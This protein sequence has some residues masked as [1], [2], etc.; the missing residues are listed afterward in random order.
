M[1]EDFEREERA[2]AEALH[3]S[4]P[5][6]TFRP[7]D[8]EAIKAAARPARPGRTRLFKGMA[9]AAVLVIVVGVGAV[10]LPRMVGSAGSVT[11]QPASGYGAGGVVPE[12]ATDRGSAASYPDKTATSTPGFRWE[13]YR[14]IQAEVPESWVYASAPQSDYCTSTRLPSKPYV[15]LNHGDGAVAAILCGTEL[16][17]DQQAL[18]VSFT[19]ADGEPPWEAPSQVWKQSSRIVGDARITVT[20]REEDSALVTSILESA[21]IVADGTT[22]AGCPVALGA[23]PAVELAGLDASQV[24][25]CQYERDSHRGAFRSSV[26][27]TGSDA[28]AAWQ[29]LLKTPEGGGPDMAAKECGD[30]QGWPLLLLVGPEQVPVAASVAGCEGNGVVDAAAHGGKRTI[31]R[32]LCHAL[33]VDPVRL[34]VGFGPSA[35]LCMR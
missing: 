26:V 35:G 23:V 13:S 33:V 18:H 29:A 28:S 14:N 32:P 5:V 25:V 24:T 27:L 19:P 22:P 7:L 9:A 31:T 30:A 11:A 12:A 10:L 21:T 15:D 17:D 16:R 8:P 6:E 4:V 2:F 34:N 1:S 20:A 3:A